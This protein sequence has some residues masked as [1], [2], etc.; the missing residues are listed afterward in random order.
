MKKDGVTKDTVVVV[1]DS[2]KAER[3]AMGKTKKVKK[4]RNFSLFEYQIKFLKILKLLTGRKI[5][6][7]D[8]CSGLPTATLS[9]MSKGSCAGDA[10]I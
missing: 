2:E 10:I 6:T 3:R 5:A 7:A 1:N 9:S 4:E 8:K